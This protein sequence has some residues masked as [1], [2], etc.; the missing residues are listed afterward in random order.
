MN[1]E[2]RKVPTGRFGRLARLAAAGVR[3]GV[4]AVVAPGEAS[5]ALEVAR[6][7]GTMR[8]LAAK[9]GQ[10]AGY[11]DGLV[12]EGQREAYES[13]LKGLQ[14]AAPPSP[15]GEVR[16]LITAELGSPPERA[17]AAFDETPFASASLG[18]VHR[19]RLHSGEEVAV[20]VQHPGVDRALEGDLANTAILEGL[21]ALGGAK[22]GP[23]KAMAAVVRQR[24][25]EELD[26]G[27]EAAA[28]ARF[29]RF[30]APDARVR[31]PRVFPECSSRRVLTT[32]FV[33]GASFDAAC[34][35][36]E[37]E[38][39]AWCETL[40][41]FVFK[42]SLVLGAFNA[43][44]HPG[45][46]LFHP[47]GAVTFLDFG[48]IQPLPPERLPLSAAV[49]RAAVGGD[50]AGF[51]RAVAALLAAPP[52]PYAEV[53]VAYTRRC[54][55]PV[56]AS[57]FRL[58]RAYAASLFDD[59]RAVAAVARKHLP[60][61][62]APIPPEVLFLNRLQFGFYS[63]LARLDALADYRAVEA[64][65]APELPAEARA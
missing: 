56:F 40:W 17:F 29:A 65:F 19:A 39:R 62:H 59:V 57:P 4:G 42:G 27:L 38:R 33:A 48:C 26:Y 44:P 50:E 53:A 51:R 7:L 41:H 58:T 20:K 14:R 12:P 2:E 32:E 10:M 5:T 61:G 3:A 8:G 37:P 60:E 13:A 1:H 47:D 46:Y 35:A 23:A 63:V 9:L 34:A 45:N 28:Q 11:I 31:I 24:F 25:L 54:F 55:E 30:F 21:A 18:Q 36:P 22:R 15:Y 43:D 6:T 64:G 49:H 16:A 52:G